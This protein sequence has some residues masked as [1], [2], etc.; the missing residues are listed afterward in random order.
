MEPLVSILIPTYN[1]ANLLKRSIQSALNQTYENIEIVIS[2]NNSD[3][4][5]DKIVNS[6]TDRRIKYFKNE[7]NI[8]PILNWR[9]ALVKSSGDYC[10]LLCDDDYIIESNYIRNSVELLKRYSNVVLVLTNCIIGRDT[11]SN[12]KLDLNEINDG[13]EYLRKF[14]EH[15]YSIPVISN[16]FKRDT[17]LSLNAFHSN[18]ILYS[19]ILLWLKLMT[20][21]D[22]A[23][24]K[25]AN[26]YYDFHGSNIV[27]N[28]SRNEIIK[29]SRFIHELRL[30]LIE[31][32][33]I[34]KIDKYIYSLTRR[35]IMFVSGIY[36]LNI[37]KK[38]YKQILEEVKIEN[39]E[40]QFMLL[41]CYQIISKIKKRAIN[42]LL[43][44]KKWIIN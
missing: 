12:T 43:R 38:F 33:V 35:Y 16:L 27:T 10:I 40:S 17:A 20:K 13:L 28:M 5:T 21:G 36:A 8:G 25:E 1:R 23:I 11:P 4:N 44:F 26:I 41:K 15:G 34:E 18:E 2:D 6:F 22:V 37:N 39:S 24:N 30:H 29:N 14:W 32:S 9:N 19:D 3:D 42:I 7:S 31:Y